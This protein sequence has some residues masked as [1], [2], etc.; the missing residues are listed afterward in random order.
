[1]GIFEEVIAQSSKKPE[2]LSG[3]VE[4]RRHKRLP[5]LRSSSSGL[6]ANL[7]ELELVPAFGLNR[8]SGAIDGLIKRSIDQNIFFESP[9]LLSA[10]PRLTSLLAPHG[11]WMLCLWETIGETREL[12][13]FMPVRLNLV[14][15]P[16]QKVLQPLSN[17]FMPLGTPL[18]DRDCA[19]EAC[20]TLLRLL[21][22]PSM[23]LP[24]VIDFTHLRRTENAFKH[25]TKAAESLG[26]PF[27]EANTHDRA[28]LFSSQ[29][30]DDTSA[31]ETKDF[32]ALSKK[33]LREL[34]RQ[35]RKLSETAEI[36]FEIAKTQDEI[37][38]AFEGF[39]TLE[40][41]GWKGRH[42]TAL[43]N[44][45]SIAAF[46]RQIVASLA[47]TNGCEIHTMKQNGKTIAGLIWLGRKGDLAPW[48]MAFEE[49]LSLYS[50]GMLMMQLSTNQIAA[51][52]SFKRADSLAVTD[53]WMMNRIWSGR[54]EITDLAICLNDGAK[55]E[56]DLVIESKKRL[57]N[58]KKKAKAVLHKIDAIQNRV[59]SL[60]GLK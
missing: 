9:V 58:W 44:H 60:I 5:T 22:D 13:L 16:R 3:I 11:A 29:D 41:K 12:R 27:A 25:L 50:P 57:S 24:S 1:M 17:E 6:S 43:Y 34:N 7:W 10:W 55:D 28:A 26:L 2:G 49:N 37:L 40:L 33:R 51:R 15:F 35:M 53:H 54:I 42:G 20:E 8:L 56:L 23:N 31:R 30:R 4:R 47:A 46:S 38:D 48:K 59:R 36:Q 21:A 32:T 52:K 39:M 45:K 18:I 14:G 19:G